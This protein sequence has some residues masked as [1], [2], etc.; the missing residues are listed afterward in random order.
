MT[1]RPNAI[2]LPVP[3]RDLP[4]ISRPVRTW[5]YVIACRQDVGG[6]GVQ[7]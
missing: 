5:S 4:M 6:G 2:V 7:V 3:V 1:G